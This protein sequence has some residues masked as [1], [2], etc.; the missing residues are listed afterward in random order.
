MVNRED[1]IG[2]PIPPQS[3][4][5]VRRVVALAA[6]RLWMQE[7][8]V[9]LLRWLPPP[10]AGAGLWLAAVRLGWWPAPWD[11][12]AMA[13]LWLWVASVVA[14]ALW[15][16]HRDLPTAMRLDRQA[17][18][19]DA[20]STALWLAGTG[21]EDGWAQVQT[22]YAATIAEKLDP[23]AVFPWP[24]LSWL[25]ALGAL[26]VLSAAGLAS[27]P[28]LHDNRR[29][30]AV[31]L[32]ITLPAG[33][34]RFASAR[35]ALGEDAAQLLTADLRLLHEVQEQVEDPA[36][37]RWLAQLRQVVD[38]VQAGRI[39][40][41]QALEQLAALQAQR[42]EDSQA[43]AE[44][45]EAAVAGDPDEAQRQ[46]DA[47]ARQA[48]LDAAQ[49]ALAQ[50]PEG[51]AKEEMKKAVQ[52]GDL[53]LL[54]KAMEKL[55]ERGVSDKDLEKWRK[56]LEQFADA[57]KDAKVPD[58]L[59]ELAKRVARLEQQR[60]AQGGLN[61]DQQRRLQQ[62][63]HELEQLRKDVGDVQGAQRQLQRLEQQARAAADE[64]RRQEPSEG[65]LGQKGGQQGE[66]G[67][68]AQGEKSQAGQGAKAQK[69][70]EVIRQAA[71]ELR[72]QDQEQKARQAQRI[73]QERLRDLRQGLSRG[74]EGP[75]QGEQ[76]GQQQGQQQ[77]GGRQGS[78]GTRPGKGQR[79]ESRSGEQAQGDRGQ[80]DRGQG[81]R[82]QGDNGADGGE[83]PA[84]GEAGQQGQ[85]KAFQLG[86]RG[87]HGKTRTDL[88]NE[89]YERK[90]GAQSAGKSGLD[91]ADPGGSEAGT[92]KG[93]EA[94]GG[95]DPGIAAARTEKLKGT[96]GEG[97][98]AKKT[99]LDTA[100][101]GFAR[102][103]WREVYA[104]YSQ[105]A[106]EMIDKE[107]LPAGRKALVRRYFEKIRP[108]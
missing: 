45:G 21:R 33:P 48:M 59:K 86:S 24:R 30:P 108:R 35:D 76:Q 66:S 104:D 91:T 14:V 51:E 16:R 26:A 62:A 72:R 17:A 1:S 95:K 100:R 102:Q 74:N 34:Q 63:R 80:G 54:A 39:D 75:E 19:Q 60:A 52:Q 15:H 28:T 106:E 5:A 55:A 87:L 18:T 56:T 31:G 89:G 77:A 71:D 22:S 105:V 44:Q 65:R 4:T 46:R 99:F 13:V 88:I 83:D 93:S 42:Q 57:L 96:Q 9:R 41:R 2:Q 68:G 81:D 43:P 3:L 6:R 61:P 70:A 84:D 50:A 11:E 92:G 58:K 8:A 27:W 107:G 97:P 67:Q 40:K 85:K 20:L 12:A 69:A 23:A 7:T 53:G 49:Q 101:R 32:D 78:K 38:D 79:G 25:A 98:D 94:R 37:R 10:I 36:T 47:A 29:A 103:G 90:R 73:G 64:M 82:G